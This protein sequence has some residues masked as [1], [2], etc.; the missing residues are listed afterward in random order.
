MSR[1]AA[2]HVVKVLSPSYTGTTWLNLVLGGHAR[3]FTI[4]PPDRVWQLREQGFDDACRVHAADCPFWPAFF[5]AYRPGENFY[6]QLAAFSGR[7]HL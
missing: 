7:D 6:L 4:G 3:A 1:P 2:V 5:R